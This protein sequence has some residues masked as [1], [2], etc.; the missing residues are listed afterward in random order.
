MKI[1]FLIIFAL[2]FSACSKDNNNDDNPTPPG[3]NAMVENQSFKSNLVESRYY[4]NNYLV[5]FGMNNNGAVIIIGINDFKGIGNY[6]FSDQSHSYAEFI[7]DTS[8][9]AKL[10]TTIKTG[11]AGSVTVTSWDS[12]DSIFNASFSF[13]GI[14]NT[15]GTS[16]AV[17]EGQIINL[18]TN[19]W[20]GSF[21]ARNDKFSVELD[22]VY[23]TPNGTL[24]AGSNQEVV[25]IIAAG[26]KGVFRVTLPI[27][28]TSGE[29]VFNSEYKINYTNEFSVIYSPIS[30]SITIVEHNK[31][32]KRIKAVFEFVGDD[33]FGNTINFS[34]GNFDIGY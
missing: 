18:K 23:Y 8:S 2:L 19:K 14:N 26:S 7:S 9:S 33:N 17:T 15:D 4:E 3:I 21:D 12:N 1:E 31:P 25:S 30:G 6:A 16:I 27:D 5:Q 34:S 10:Y 13:T 20:A 22:G 32:N 29:Y 28:I 11:G 24:D